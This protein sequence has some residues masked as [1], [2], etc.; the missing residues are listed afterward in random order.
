VTPAAALSGEG[1][2]LAGIRRILD[3]AR[4]VD[5]GGLKFYQWMERASA[6]QQEQ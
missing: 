4:G 3:H 1:V 5:S 6:T 2:N